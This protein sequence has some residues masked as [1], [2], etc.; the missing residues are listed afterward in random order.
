M[1]TLDWKVNGELFAEK[2]NKTIAILK[3]LD[4]RQG[5]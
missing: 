1:S 3:T 5:N 2:I 4:K